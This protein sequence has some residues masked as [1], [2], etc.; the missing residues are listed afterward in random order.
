M[1]CWNFP[2]K[3]CH[4]DDVLSFVF[5]HLLGVSGFVILETRP[6]ILYPTN[7]Y[8]D[9]LQPQ[10]QRLAT[11]WRNQTKKFH[12]I[13]VTPLESN[14]RWLDVFASFNWC[15]ENLSTVRNFA[16]TFG[17]G[18]LTQISC[19]TN[20]LLIQGQ[21]ASLL[22]HCF[23]VLDVL[24]GALSSCTLWW[25]V[26]IRKTKVERTQVLHGLV[27][28]T[29]N[30]YRKQTWDANHFPTRQNHH[31]CRLKTVMNSE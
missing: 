10:V 15:T 14:S 17:Y 1:V 31:L 5:S 11:K 9:N 23:K 20:P 22:A 27:I 2:S 25:F 7:A 21:D 18:T 13:F 30:T 6:G 16:K 28:L 3:M 12:Y 26:W 4:R 29:S 19:C 24:D 8:Q